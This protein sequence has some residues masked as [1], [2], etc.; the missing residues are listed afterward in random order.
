MKR[1]EKKSEKKKKTPYLTT[2]QSCCPAL[3][4]PPL[5]LLPYATVLGSMPTAG[6]EKTLSILW[7]NG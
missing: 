6:K 1:H 5:S 3:L 2:P 4:L 7:D